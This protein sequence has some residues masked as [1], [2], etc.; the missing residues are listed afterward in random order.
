MARQAR[1]RPPFRQRKLAI[2]FTP[3]RSETARLAFPLCPRAGLTLQPKRGRRVRHALLALLRQAQALQ[4][5]PGQTLAVFH[6]LLRA[7]P[8][9][10]GSMAILPR[11]PER[12]RLLL[13]QLFLRGKQPERRRLS[14]S[15]AIGPLIR[16]LR[17]RRAVI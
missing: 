14:G 1:T 16:R 13:I 2:L 11:R 12:L 17:R 7:A 9:I 8:G 4:L 3:L 5:A 6:L 15:L 10:T